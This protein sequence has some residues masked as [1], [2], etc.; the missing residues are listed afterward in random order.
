MSSFLIICAFF[1][2]FLSENIKLSLAL[3]ELFF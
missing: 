3:Y 1:M 2:S